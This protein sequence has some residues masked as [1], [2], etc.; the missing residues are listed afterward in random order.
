MSDGEVPELAPVFPVRVSI[1]S[2][3]PGLELV[4]FL[5]WTTE[6]ALPF[7]GSWSVTIAS[8]DTAVQRCRF[9]SLHSAAHFAARIAPMCDWTLPYEDVRTW[10]SDGEAG[11]AVR[12]AEAHAHEVDAVWPVGSVIAM[13][14]GPSLIDMTGITRAFG[15]P[16]IDWKRDD[17]GDWRCEVCGESP[18]IIFE[19][20]Q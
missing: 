14:N 12:H 10:A 1:E 7:D 13:S 18:S 19:W 20:M 16:S 11:K 6:D 3:V 17:E 5:I 15:R 2:G 4:H 8:V 9:R